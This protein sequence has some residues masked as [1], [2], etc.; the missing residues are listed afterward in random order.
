MLH[1]DLSNER[2]FVIGFRA[3]NSLLIPRDKSLRD[4]IANVFSNKYL[5]SDINEK[6]LKIATYLYWNSPYNTALV[7]DDE[8]FKKCGGEETFADLPFSNIYNIVSPSRVT[9]ML[10]T[11][12]LSYYVDDCEESRYLA[13]SKYAVSSEEFMKIMQ[14]RGKERPF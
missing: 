5:R 2:G 1:G 11:G 12:E 10:N 14:T 4:R 3:E 13:Q 8:V 7:I 6:V 9:S